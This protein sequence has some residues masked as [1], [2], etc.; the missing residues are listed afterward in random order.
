MSDDNKSIKEALKESHLPENIEQRIKSR[1]RQDYLRDAMLG[2]VDGGVSTFAI[3]AGTIGG[4]FPALVALALGL[5]SLIAD[6][7]SMAISNFQATKSVSDKLKQ[8]RKAEAYQIEHVPEGERSEIRYIFSQKGFSGELLEQIVEV[9]T[10]DKRR[11]IDT[12][13]Q[14]EFG[15]PLTAPNPLV[16]AGMTYLAFLVVG[17]I[18]LIPFFWAKN[19]LDLT[20]MLSCI[21]TGGSFALVGIVKGIYLETSIVR[22]ALEV[23]CLGSFAAI[24]SYYISHWVVLAFS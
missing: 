9:I 1:Y 6:G 21:L 8:V 16:A 20:F 13:V 22:S 5:A 17:L 10:K 14:E 23:L 24:S 2:G 19:N 4:G 11:W 18:P 7:L 3:V 12:M 15:L